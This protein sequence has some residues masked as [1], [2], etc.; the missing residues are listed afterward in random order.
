MNGSDFAYLRHRAGFDQRAAAQFLD[1]SVRTVRR[2]ETTGAPRMAVLA[3]AARA[4][5]Y[6]GW[7]GYRFH[8]GALLTPLGDRVTQ[9]EI[10]QRDYLV[11]LA[12]WRGWE[13][14]RKG[15][16]EPAPKR[17]ALHIVECA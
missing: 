17:P 14:H 15:E 13:A 10:E 4:G 8:D 5:E 3:L 7:L 12:W 16:P 1:V 2:Y 6:P 9:T 11:Y